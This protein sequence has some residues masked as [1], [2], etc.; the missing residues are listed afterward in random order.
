ME[1]KT[2]LLKEAEAD[3]KKVEKDLK[4]QELTYNKIADEI[5]VEKLKFELDNMKKGL[6]QNDTPIE[7]LLS[8]VKASVIDNE[9]TITSDPVYRSIWEADEIEEIKFLI[10]QKARKL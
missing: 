2:D 5:A 1:Q 10:M 3:V 8:V 4:L 6:G 7:Q 9:R